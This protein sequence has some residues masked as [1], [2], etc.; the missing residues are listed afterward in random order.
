MRDQDENRMSSEL[1]DAIELLREAPAVRPEWRDELLRRA[2]ANAR[3]REDYATPVRAMRRVSLSVPWAVAAGV[4]CALIGASATILLR[5]EPR[6]SNIVAEQHI[7]ASEGVMLPVRFS[8]HAPQA[9]RVSI[10]GDFNDWNPT[11]LPM[12]RSA[13]GR[14][15]EV[16]VRLPLGRYNYAFFVD[17]RLAPDPGAPSTAD[18]D[19]GTPSSV[20]MV[21]GS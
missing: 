10:V 13:D 15:W 21:R 9:G 3:T 7:A 6:P 2:N 5:H 8:L 4:V 16:E 19:F 20:L 18:D 11:T 1:S 12:R 17:G 14:V